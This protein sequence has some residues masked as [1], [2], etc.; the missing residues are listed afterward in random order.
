MFRLAYLLS[1]PLLLA[2]ATSAPAAA[3]YNLTNLSARRGT[4]LNDRGEVL[5]SVSESAGGY[6]GVYRSLDP[7]GEDIRLPPRVAS[8]P[9]AH[10]VQALGDDGALY[11]F[12]HPLVGPGPLEASRRT[13][14][15]QSTAIAP[16]G[17][18]F[19]M[20]VGANADGFVVGVYSNGDGLNSVFVHHPATATTEA[21]TVDLGHLSDLGAQP[22]APNAAGQFLV[23]VTVRE[24]N[25]WRQS[26][27]LVQPDGRTTD[28]GRPDLSDYAK[29]RAL[30]DRGQG[31]GEA[32][33]RDADGWTRG[34]AVLWEDGTWIPLV[35]P[36][37]PD[38]RVSTATGINNA[39]DIL[40]GTSLGPR[41]IR[42]GLWYDL[43]DLYD[44]PTGRWDLF[45][46]IAINDLGQILAE[47]D[48]RW[49]EDW[50][51]VRALALLTPKTLGNPVAPSNVVPE[52]A[53]LASFL[54]LAALLAWRRLAC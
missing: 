37:R 9:L 24:D 3:L 11:G 17:T 33:T 26:T 50:Q 39:G 36:G 16:T 34:Q 35:M 15:G 48:V 46:A 53:A 23:Q 29:V 13:L 28:L 52:P 31:V 18:P 42:D 8:G 1:I 5:Y 7:D 21:R 14:D 49:G 19:S 4:S 51:S 10:N 27:L 25:G 6:L 12:R 47:G 32:Y 40:V 2:L 20:A 41:V 38:V 43:D 30:N 45:R 22:T 44:D 54:A